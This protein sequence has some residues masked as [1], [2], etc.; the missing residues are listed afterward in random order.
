[1]KS[2]AVARY[3]SMLNTMAEL[4]ARNSALHAR[5]PAIA[6][7]G[8]R[9]TH[10]DLAAKA[11]SLAHAVNGLGHGVSSRMAV[12]SQNRSEY[13]DV[14]AAA[15]VS[16]LVAVTVN[17]R[18]AAPEVAQVLDDAEPAL[19]FTEERF[20]P[21][22]AQAKGH[23]RKTR[24]RIVTFGPDFES[25]L[26]QGKTSPGVYVPSADDIAHIIYT[27]GTTGAPKGVVISQQ[28]VVNAAFGIALM[29]GHGPADRM[30]VS[31]PLFHSGA[32]VEWS[33]VQ[34]VGGSCVLLSQFDPAEVL[35]II[36]H[37]KITM[38]ILRL[39]WS[40]DSSN[41]INMTATISA[42]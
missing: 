20:L 33:S 14:Y 26:A 17:W 35:K 34:A 12:L 15:E 8:Q 23:M 18:L 29:G 41:N 2:L 6:F 16:G 30:L 19:L 11:W 37:E 32:K 1:M 3:N 5:R 36:G 7:E 25:L 24:P 4:I 21:L 40:R 10:S 22:Y 9:L 38:A 13:L 27:S 39:S 28:A 31:M 42:A